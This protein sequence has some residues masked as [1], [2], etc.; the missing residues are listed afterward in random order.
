MV[1]GVLRQLFSA[2]SLMG[3][4]IVGFLYL[5]VYNYLFVNFVYE[6]FSYMGVD[7]VPMSMVSTALWLILSIA[8]FLFS[9]V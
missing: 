4:M 7:Y 1:K 2:E 5:F 6:N 3:R 8:P 9:G